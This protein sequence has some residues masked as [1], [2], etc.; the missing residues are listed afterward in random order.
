MPRAGS[1]AMGW[2]PGRTALPRPYLG[3]GSGRRRGESGSRLGAG[4][5]A[6][7]RGDAGVAVRVHQAV[8]FALERGR[9]GGTNLNQPARFVGRVVHQRGLVDDGLVDFDDFAAEGGVEV[10]GG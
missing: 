10:G 3:V 7:S 9:I 8:E 6:C 5:W 1:S 4:S 2:E